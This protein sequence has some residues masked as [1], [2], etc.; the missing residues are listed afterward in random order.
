MIMWRELRAGYS[1]LECK[2]HLILAKC[3][4]LGSKGKKKT[5]KRVSG[6]LQVNDSDRQGEAEHRL[7]GEAELW[8]LKSWDS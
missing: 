4:F 2:T 5:H 7:L 1:L 3:S 8:Y 6:H